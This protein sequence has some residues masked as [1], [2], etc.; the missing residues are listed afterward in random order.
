VSGISAISTPRA[1]A[2]AFAIAGAV[3]MILV[4]TMLRSRPREEKIALAREF[5][6]RAVPLFE[7]GRLRPVVD[8]VLPVTSIRQ[9]HEALERGDTF[10]KVVVKV[11]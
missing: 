2:T 5:A 7:S 11:E 8:R 10:G 1:S 9:A 6:E 4:G 3:G